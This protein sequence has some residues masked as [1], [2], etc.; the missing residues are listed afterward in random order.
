MAFQLITRRGAL[1]GLAATTLHAAAVA[2]TTP[3]R[4]GVLKVS[5]S[6]RTASLNPLQISGPS[7]YIAIDMLYSGLMR[8]GADMK[9]APDLAL[10]YKS[11]AE[12]KVFEFKLRPDV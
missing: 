6:T 10:D 2:Q 8:M 9:A 7:E 12:A 11:D 5:V 3:K 1:S 4:G